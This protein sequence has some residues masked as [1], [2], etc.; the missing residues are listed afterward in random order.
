MEKIKIRIYFFFLIYFL[1]NSNINC[2]ECSGC[3][4]SG[5]LCKH[6]DESTES[7]PSNCMYDIEKKDCFPCDG[8]ERGGYY[9]FD[10]DGCSKAESCSKIIYN[11]FQ[12]VNECPDSYYSFGKYCYQSCSGNMKEKDGTNEC[13]CVDKYYIDDNSQEHCL[14]DGVN[15]NPEHQYYYDKQC[16]T[17]PCTNKKLKVETRSGSSNIFQCLDSCD[18]KF[19]YKQ[20]IQEYCVDDCP[21]DKFLYY[22]TN[23]PKECIDKCTSVYPYQKENNECVKI[24]SCSYINGTKCIESPNTCLHNKVEN[25]ELNSKKCVEFCL[26]PYLYKNTND[27]TCN[28]EC[29]FINRN[30]ECVTKTEDCFYTETSKDAVNKICYSSCKESPNPFQIYDS[31]NSAISRRCVKQCQD[32]DPYLYKFEN[33]KIC[34]QKDDFPDFMK[35]IDDNYYLGSDNTYHCGLYAIKDDGSYKCYKNEKGCIDDGFSFKIDEHQCVKECTSF[36]YEVPNNNPKTKLDEC[37]S[38]VQKCKDKNYYYYNTKERRCYISLPDNAN[39][40]EIDTENRKPKEDEGKNT[41]TRGCESLLFPKKTTKGIC[42]KE[43]DKDEYFRPSKPNE[44]L[45]SCQ[46]DNDDTTTYYIGYNNECLT[47]CPHYYIEISGQKKCVKYCKDYG[48]YYFLGDHKC[49]NSCEKNN[50]KYYYNIDDNKCV[51]TCMDNSGTNKYAYEIIDAPQPCLN[52]PDGKYYDINNIILNEKCKL[53]SRDDP[54][55]CVEHCNG[56]KVYNKRCVSEC[57]DKYGLYV[58]KL[59]DGSTNIYIDKCVSQ[60]PEHYTKI[61]AYRNECV[62]KCPANYIEDKDGRCFY[63][64]CPKGLKYNPSSLKCEDCSPYEKK[65]IEIDT[66]GTT[67]DIYICKSSCN[68]ELKYIKDIN[69]QECVEHC[70]PQ[71]NYIGGD[72]ICRTHCNGNHSFLLETK[73]S[74]KY[75]QCVKHCPTE[76]DYFYIVEYKGNDRI[77]KEECVLNCPSTFPFGVKNK[78][79][80]L[81]TCPSDKPYYYKTEKTNDDK[82]YT[83]TSKFKCGYGTYSDKKYYCEDDCYNGDGIKGKKKLYVKDNQCIEEEDCPASY[84]KQRENYG[85]ND[86]FICKPECDPNE[87]IKGDECLKR[88][89]KDLNYIDKDNKCKSS[90]RDESQATLYYRFE[91]VEDLNYQIYKCVEECPY[92]YIYS[93]N[94][95]LCLNSCEE[96]HRYLSKKDNFCYI[97]CF[98]QSENSKFSLSVVVGTNT[99]TRCLSECNDPEYPDYKYYYKNVQVCLKKCFNDDYAVE[100]KNECVR[101]C[102]SL[103]EDYYYYDTG[104]TNSQMQTKFCVK[105]CPPSKNFIRG[106]TCEASCDTNSEEKFHIKEYRHGEA[107]LQRKCSSDCTSGYPYYYDDGKYECLEAC[108]TG[109]YFVPKVS[110]DKNATLCFYSCNYDNQTYKYKIENETSKTCYKECPGERPFHKNITIAGETDNKCYSVCPPDASFHEKVEDKTRFICKTLDKCNNGYAN[111]E[112]KECLAREETCPDGSKLSE[113]QGKI[114]CLYQCM[115]PYG[116]YPTEYNTCVNDCASTT[117]SLVKDL[118]LKKDPQYPQCI[119]E[120]LYYKT[121]DDKKICFG[122]SIGK[123]CKNMTH[124]K[125]NLYGTKECILTCN[126]IGILSPLEDICFNDDYDCHNYLNTKMY[127]KTLNENDE[128][129]KKCDCVDKYYYKE[130]GEKICLAEGEICPNGYDQKYIPEKKRCLKNGDSCPPLFSHLFLGK[131]CLRLCPANSHENN[132]ECTCDEGYDYWHEVSPSNLECIKDCYDIH[133]VSIPSENN[134]CV[135][136]C[137]GH[138]S[139][140][141]NNECYHTCEQN[142]DNN[143]KILGAIEVYDEDFTLSKFKCECKPGDSWYIDDNNIKNCVTDCY[144][145]NPPFKYT[146]KN[147]SQCVNTC[148]PDYYIFNNECF[149]SCEDEAYS[150]YHLN[151]KTV[152]NFHDC[153]CRGLWR[154]TDSENNFKECL[155]ED[156]CALPNTDKRF[157]FNSTQCL[158]ECPSGWKGFNFLCSNNCPQNTIDK[159]SENGEFDCTCN[160]NDGYWYEYQEYGNTYYVCGLEECPKYHKTADNKIFVR[161]NLIESERKCVNSCR[162]EGRQDNKKVYALRNICIEYC[163]DYTYTNKDDDACLFFDLNDT[164]ITY[165]EELKNAANV[166]V[167]ELYE[168]SEKTG[169][170]LFNKFNASLEI[171]KVKKDNSLKDIS[172][173]SNLTYIDFGACLDKLYS[174]KSIGKGYELLVAK[175]DLLP[176]A[177]IN[178]GEQ[179]SENKNLDKYLINPVEYGLYSSNMSEALDAHVCEPYEILISYPLVFNKFD[180][181]IDGIVQNEYR[182]K[183]QIG[184]DLYHMDNEIDTFNYSNIIYKNFCRGLEIDGKDLV[185]E[186]RY[187][188]LYPNNKILCESNCTLNNTD[189][190]LGRVNCLCKYKNI[191]DLNR[192]EKQTNDILNDPNFVLPTQSQSNIEVLNCLFDFNL[193]Q[194]IIFND[195]FYFCL[196]GLIAQIVMLILSASVGIKDASI[197]IKQL[198]NKINLSKNNIGKK[199]KTKKNPDFKNEDIIGSTNR[200]LN[201]PP[202]K[203]DVNENTNEDID[204]DSINEE[205]DSN[206]NNTIIDN[207]SSNNDGGNYEINLK[208]ENKADNQTKTLDNNDGM[209]V[210]YIPPEYNFKFFKSSDKGVMKKLERSKVPFEIN[211]DTKYLIER[212]EGIEYPEDYLNGP[213]YQDQNIVILIDEIN[214]DVDKVAKYIKNEKISKDLKPK[215]KNN[216]KKI[217]KNIK[218]N[219]K[220]N[221]DDDKI[222]KNMKKRINLFGSK[223][224]NYSINEKSSIEFKKS[225]QSIQRSKIDY[226]NETLFEEFYEENDIKLNKDEINLFSLVKREQLFLRIDYD[227]Y[228]EKKHGNVLTLF[229]AEIL[230][231]IYFVKICLF[232]KRVDIFSIHCSLYILCHIIL[233]SLLCGFFSIRIIKKIWEEENFPGLNFYLLYGLISHIIVWVVYQMFL[234]ILDNQ[235]KVKDLIILKNES[236]NIN[237]DNIDI[238]DVDEKNENIITKKYNDIIFQMKFKTAL[239]YIISLLLSLFLTIYLISFFSLYT[240]TKRRVLKAYYISIIEILFIKFV[241]GLILSLLRLLSTAYR[242]KLLYD[243]VR[244]FNKYIS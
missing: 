112:T 132:N 208:K 27:N 227:I 133:L 157:L 125:I 101:D 234:C 220:T 99:I 141:Y 70:P 135:E 173:K 167:K 78:Y 23:E 199:A 66:S 34:F 96:P 212:R 197:D 189:F 236:Q 103:D 17:E 159:K 200:P 106:R 127:N 63:A 209:K 26:S 168:K 191:L 145:M 46:I 92:N 185:F 52:K 182:T 171:Y 113:Y 81:Q 79:E 240:G 165:L 163:P 98:S 122:G 105:K 18:T 202:K 233:L 151:I 100:I 235:D 60:C 206:N 43:C 8:I 77:A 195:A 30:N 53:I 238:D 3:D 10:G 177:N 203:N 239:F 62:E 19:F 232:L 116:K 214:N 183:F 20:G 59:R 89:P 123:E 124:H 134:K 137:E 170:F 44:C 12:C 24:D 152:G 69:D 29:N 21:K 222:V 211:P 126:G 161:N 144:S 120:N 56:M 178:V 83:C 223:K 90:C 95:N 108:Q 47:S 218:E 94:D 73:E 22:G 11:T 156:I 142:I 107:D 119:C 16:F 2:N 190:E 244:I 13:E 58:H 146:I 231:K 138:Y 37:Y 148:P 28:K 7:C 36:I 67:K 243:I 188:Y 160:L 84:K 111:Y 166:Q 225:N 242:V 154:Y 153:Q 192:T 75:Y 1:F 237:I 71:N 82:Y 5:N 207:N 50:K 114:V 186:D 102:S 88:C 32:A 14:G 33:E 104:E 150:K 221:K 176:G 131:Y 175:Y 172:F 217:D 210:E 229:L 86:I 42:K 64:E 130:N 128:A 169:G 198:L 87:Y 121:N 129:K 205:K 40:N 187:K 181:V 97:N 180:K 57:P 196:V 164:R 109:H 41:Y 6:H 49:Y 226:S 228:I 51:E 39:S 213:Y 110:P 74:I 4:K 118:Y 85:D 193:K 139:R 117:N 115:E 80:C 216:D 174:D 241:Y 136:K 143:L 91:K 201:N 38:S 72:Y 25:D 31:S 68:T 215:N 194:A 54:Q 65:K 230:D 149:T 9:I 147:T 76:K 35:D 140:F 179:I 45:S 224:N 48:K 184:K 219:N 158:K 162:K 55:K 204:I 15:C 155:L 93:S 61:I